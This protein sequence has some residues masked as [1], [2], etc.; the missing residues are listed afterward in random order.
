MHCP[1]HNRLPDHEVI[2]ATWSHYENAWCGHQWETRAALTGNKE[3][4][5]KQKRRPFAG[6]KDTCLC[7]VALRNS[8][9][10]RLRHSAQGRAT[11]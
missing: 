2:V 7:L 9:P 3:A 6:L 10:G 8:L 5:K 11:R 1:R 4:K